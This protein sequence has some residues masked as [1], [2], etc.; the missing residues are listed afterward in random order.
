MLKEELWKG[1]KTLT[2]QGLSQNPHGG[3]LLHICLLWDFVFL[4]QTHLALATTRHRRLDYMDHGSD[5]PFGNFYS[6]LFPLGMCC[7]YIPPIEEPTEEN[8]LNEG[9]LFHSCHPYMVLLN[10]YL[11]RGR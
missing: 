6:V 2:F 4:T 8:L 10:S 5:H 7:D 11:V 3:G 9:F 1:S